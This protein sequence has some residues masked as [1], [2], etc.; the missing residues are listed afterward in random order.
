[1]RSASRY[2]RHDLGTNAKRVRNLIDD[3][4]DLLSTPQ[5]EKKAAPPPAHPQANKS[6]QAKR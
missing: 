6:N 2:G 1:V 5:P 3:I 4:D